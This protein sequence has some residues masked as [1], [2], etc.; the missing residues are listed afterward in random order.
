[1]EI[2]NPVQKGVLP[3]HPCKVIKAHLIH[4][5]LPTMME[6]EDKHTEVTDRVTTS[7]LSRVICN[8][9]N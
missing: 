6:N 8:D 5:G 4:E 1:M 9:L 7:I 2:S 3:I